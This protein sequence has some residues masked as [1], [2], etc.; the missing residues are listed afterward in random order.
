[1]SSVVIF[2]GL[3]SISKNRCEFRYKKKNKIESRALLTTVRFSHYEK[4]IS[5]DPTFLDKNK[6]DIDKFGSFA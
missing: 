2:D 6:R 5:L 4:P 3:E 1:L